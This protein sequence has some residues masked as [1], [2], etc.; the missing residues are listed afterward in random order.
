MTNLIWWFGVADMFGEHKLVIGRLLA[1]SFL[2]ILALYCCILDK[3]DFYCWFLNKY[4]FRTVLT[5]YVTTLD[6]FNKLKL[7]MYYHWLLYNMHCNEVNFFNC[8]FIEGYISKCLI[9]QNY[10]VISLISGKLPNS[11]CFKSS[12]LACRQRWSTLIR[13]FWSIF[14][15]YTLLF[16]HNHSY[17]LWTKP[18]LK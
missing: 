16:M 5:W 1:A 11:Q 9:K 8:V 10:S 2:S 13:I 15:D 12:N 18:L 14:F 7:T 4:L 17:K 6:S 3:R